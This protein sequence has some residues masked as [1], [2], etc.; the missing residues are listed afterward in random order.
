MIAATA[1]STSAALT[2]VASSRR[3]KAGSNP[4]SRV[5]SLT[6]IRRLRESRRST[7]SVLMKPVSDRRAKALDPA[8]DLFRMGLQR[9]PVDDQPRADLCDT[10][11]LDQTVRLQRGPSLHEIDDVAAETE[12]RS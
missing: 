8:T 7:A 10:L 3:W 5:A 1:A 9:R 2:R 12:M 11:D 4:A 6:G